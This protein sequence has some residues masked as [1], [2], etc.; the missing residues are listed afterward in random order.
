[1]RV[2][3]TAGVAIIRSSASVIGPTPVRPNNS[4]VPVLVGWYQREGPSERSSSEVLGRTD[5]RE[6]ALEFSPAIRCTTPEASVPVT[7]RERGRPSEGWLT[8]LVLGFCLTSL[9]GPTC[10]R[11]L[12][13]SYHTVDVLTSVSGGN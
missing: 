11:L 10:T 2:L 6:L 9:S 8:P 13:G 12:S 4:G 7:D 1:M 5:S 3:T